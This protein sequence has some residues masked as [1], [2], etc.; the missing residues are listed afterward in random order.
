MNTIGIDIG[1]TTMRGILWD[2]ERIARA[3]EMATPQQPSVFIRRVKEI[4]AKAA[5]AKRVASIGIGIAGVIEK[6]TLMLAPNIPAV[7]NVDL[8][9]LL[10]DSFSVRVDNDARCFARA[11]SRMGAA[12][13]FRS[14]FA[15]TLGTGIGRAFVKN[16]NTSLIKKFEYPEKWEKEYQRARDGE[17]DARLAEFLGKKLSPLIKNYDPEALVIGGGIV[18]RRGFFQRVSRAL[19]QHHVLATIRRAKL[20]E[21]AAAIGAALLFNDHG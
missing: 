18:K 7:K 17:T 1:G 15:I 5:G 4:A 2:G 10:P 9:R 14:V 8:R 12:K 11:E 6:T 16:G 21:N 13:G 3:S 20:G 19:K